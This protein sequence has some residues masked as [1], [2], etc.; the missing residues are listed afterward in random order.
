VGLAARFR[1]NE[2]QVYAVMKR[3]KTSDKLSHEDV[4]L[5]RQIANDSNALA[6][7]RLRAID[8][9]ACLGGVYNTLKC[10]VDTYIPVGT[11]PRREVVASLRK[12]L[13]DEP[14]LASDVRERLLFIR[15]G[16]ALN[17]KL[18]WRIDQNGGKPERVPSVS[19]ANLDEKL[20]LI[21]EDF[22]AEQNAALK[23]DKSYV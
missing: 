23:E 22:Y 12:L 20:K 7:R 21:E 18:L 8:R 1:K 14:A 11:R 2:R 6:S 15:T 9:L 13:R 3:A 17:P 19:F 5:L 10:H 4:G 16:E